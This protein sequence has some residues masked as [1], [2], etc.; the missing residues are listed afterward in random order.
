VKARLAARKSRKGGKKTRRRAGAAP[1]GEVGHEEIARA[2]IEAVCLVCTK[3]PKTMKLQPCGHV[4]VCASC[5]DAITTCP[6]C[7]AFVTG[8]D[9]ASPKDVPN[10]NVK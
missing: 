7:K 3:A 8:K 4:C 2:L 5:G 6:L 1:E 10:A 9:A